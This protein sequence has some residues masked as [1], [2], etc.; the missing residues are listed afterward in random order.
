MG[1]QHAAP[2]L[3]GRSTLRPYGGR[4]TL[5]AFAGA[6]PPLANASANPGISCSPWGTTIDEPPKSSPTGS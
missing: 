3:G 2:L 5:V 6:A 1:A 4:S